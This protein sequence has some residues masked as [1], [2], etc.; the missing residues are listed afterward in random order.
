MSPS[1]GSAVSMVI[2]QLGTREV[3]WMDWGTRDESRLCFL[4]RAS[5]SITGQKTACRALEQTLRPW[6]SSL[7]W[8]H[9][10]SL[11]LLILFPFLHRSQSLERKALMRTSHLGLDAPKPHCAYCLA[12]GFFC[13]LP[14]APRSFSEEGLS[15]P[16]IPASHWL[17]FF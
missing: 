5:L 15:E 4:C 7:S 14:S 6:P 1:I 12:V 2:V 16:P 8:S 17:V 11:A 13:W 9:L 3:S 10:L